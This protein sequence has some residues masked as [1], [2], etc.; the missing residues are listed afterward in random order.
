[1]SGEKGNSGTFIYR[2]MTPCPPLMLCMQRYEINLSY[3]YLPQLKFLI[4]LVIHFSHSL[5]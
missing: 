4:F 3:G 5:D 1:M 2:V